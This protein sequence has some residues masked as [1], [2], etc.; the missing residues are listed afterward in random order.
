MENDF[1]TRKEISNLFQVSMPTIVRWESEGILRPISNTGK[2][3]YQK[4]AIQELMGTPPAPAAKE[5]KRLSITDLTSSVA[6]QSIFLVNAI[7]SLDAKSKAA[8]MKGDLSVIKNLHDPSLELFENLFFA[9]KNVQHSNIYWSRLQPIICDDLLELMDY[10]SSLT[11]SPVIVLMGGNFHR[12]IIEIQEDGKIIVNAKNKPSAI[13]ILR[14][15][16]NTIQ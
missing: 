8:V 14:N 11:G 1:Y 4:S 5:Q 15:H 7:S 9:L 2:R 13:N 16:L 3:F 12:R 10:V 6:I